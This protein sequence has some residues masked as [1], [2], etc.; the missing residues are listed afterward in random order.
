MLVEANG[1]FAKAAQL[2]DKALAQD[3][4]VPLAHR[5]QALVLR[6]GLA[7]SMDD[8]SLA[9]KLLD[10]VRA[11]PLQDDERAELADVLQ[12]ANDLEQMLP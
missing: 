11:L 9:S 2:L 3:E 8:K 4:P 6:A 12:R 10:E 5:V 7:V 1:D